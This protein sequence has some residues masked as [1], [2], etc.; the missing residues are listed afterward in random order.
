[1]STLRRYIF[2][3]LLA[4]MALSHPLQADEGDCYTESRSCAIRPS[5]ALSGLV[6]VA[7]LAIT[8]Q[9]NGK[10]PESHHHE[11]QIHAH[12]GGS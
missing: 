1:M 7:I 5:W 3:T 4:S 2:L 6:I 11:K 12:I 8:L 9:R 10:C